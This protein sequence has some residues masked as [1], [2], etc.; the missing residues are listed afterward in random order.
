V[1]CARLGRSFGSGRACLVPP[2]VFGIGVTFRQLFLYGAAPRC[3]RA[4][5][6]VEHPERRPARLQN[7]RVKASRTKTG[8][9]FWLTGAWSSHLSFSHNLIQKS[10]NA[11]RIIPSSLPATWNHV[12]EKEKLKFKE[13]GHVLI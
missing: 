2:P 5:G 10:A 6:A 13:L 12:I 4:A 9:N 11:M 7:Q 3:F 8:A 1:T